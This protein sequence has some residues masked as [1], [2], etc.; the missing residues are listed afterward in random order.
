[1]AGLYGDTS[2]AG[3]NPMLSVNNTAAQELHLAM[4]P[5]GA[6]TSS[7]ARYAQTGAQK[8]T[9]LNHL[10]NATRDVGHAAA[11]GGRFVGTGAAKLVNTGIA[12]GKQVGY[13]AEM[14]A[15]TA[16]HN[17]KAFKNANTASQNAYKNDNQDHKGILGVGT[18]FKN[19]QEAQSGSLKTGLKRIGGTTL[20]AAGDVLPLGKLS[21]A[22]KIYKAGEGLVDVSKAS[23]IANTAEKSGKA[24]F[25]STAKEAGKQAAV[26]GVSSGLAS[27]GSQL[28]ENGKISVGQTA[29]SATTGALIGGVA[30]GVGKVFAAGSKAALDKIKGIPK[31]I[32][33]KGVM[34]DVMTGEQVD[35]VAAIAHTKINVNQAPNAAEKVA[36]TTPLR[37]GI[38][39]VSE[40]NKINVRTPQKM[41]DEQF[42]GEF[43]KLNNS[44][45]K[46]TK[47]LQA[48]SKILP[49]QQLKAASDKV[50]A[51][52]QT[53]LN[54]LQDRYHNPELS[55]PIAPK[56]LSSQTL[57]AGKTNGGTQK[58]STSKVSELGGNRPNDALQTQIEKAHNSGDTAG[59]ERLI[60][61][62]PDASTR[63][64]MRSSVG[65][66]TKE[67]KLVI[68]AG[69][70]ERIPLTNVKPNSRVTPQN[71]PNVA[72]ISGSSLKQ[73][74]R[75][76]QQGLVKDFENK[77]TYSSGSHTVEAEK[78]VKLVH[79]D[80]QKA[81]DIATGKISGDNTMHE[82]AVRRALE[83]KAS[84]DG[85]VATMQRLA[86]STQHTVTSEAAQRLGA[87]AYHSESN[88]AV[89]HM[90]DV[91]AIRA[92]AYEKKTG[93]PLAKTLSKSAKEIDSH[94]VKPDKYDWQNFVES[95]KC[96]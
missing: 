93:Q 16:S 60:Q 17:P 20:Q 3:A 26:G 74:Q 28:T 8:T 51:K 94:I 57:P 69:K 77:A 4:S 48:S 6:P 71:E 87:E 9:F 45:D 21:K 85:D 72:K 27:A 81:L 47:Q 62:L 38:K 37:P 59:T 18:A 91:N 31:G 53:K 83:N 23:K 65:L 86:A 32:E 76:V 40:T 90:R 63:D 96:G 89:E 5:P 50:D 66:P 13:T 49:P 12:E 15:A 82:V 64:A 95:I 43:K 7:W 11:A 79:E 61:Q 22:A 44:Y 54:D 56:K 36:V 46:E 34:S 52:Y 30:G 84:Q 10:A 2:V 92:A 29:K 73:E 70:A 78:A 80:P 68:N 33:S 41:S 58:I 55:A 75:A 88:N 25:K 39:Q 42:H 67:T 1:M 19:G 35:K 14:G 24:L